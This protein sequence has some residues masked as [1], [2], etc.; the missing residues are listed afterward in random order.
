MERQIVKHNIKTYKVDLERAIRHPILERDLGIVNVDEAKIFCL[1]LPKL[2][3][4][5]WTEVTRK[6]ALAVGA[7]Q[8]GFDAHDTIDITK[9]TT[10]LQQLT[11][12]SGDYFSGIHYKL[13]ASIPDFDFIRALSKTIGEV[14][15]TKTNFQGHA[16]THH[17]Q[18]LEALQIVD[19]GCIKQFLHSFGFAKYIPVI[20]ALLPILVINGND[21]AAPKSFSLARLGWRIED[22][23]KEAANRVLRA[24]MRRALEESDFIAPSLQIEIQNMTIQLLGKPI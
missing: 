4:E 19:V 12:L 3:G 16:P 15:E 7:V 20:S 2:N 6:A 5:K 24:E 8:A 22:A 23:E 18:L 17:A 1:L 13:L 10:T 21:G 14:N 11:V 9:S